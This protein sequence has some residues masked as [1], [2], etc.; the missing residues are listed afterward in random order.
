[1]ADIPARIYRRLC[2]ALVQ[3]A[4]FADEAALRAI[5]ADGRI[6][7]WRDTLRQTDS[8][9]A[10]VQATIAHLSERHN[11]HGEN[12]LVLLLR[13]LADQT[14]VDD[15]RH[16]ALAQL[17]ADL[18]HALTHLGQYELCGVLGRGQYATVYK[19]RDTQTDRWVAL[20]E[21]HRLLAVDPVFLDKFNAEARLAKRLDH[22]RLVKVYK[23]DVVDGRPFMVMEL[24]A[25]S[26]RGYLDEHGAVGEALA[27]RIVA[28]VA[29]AL[30]YLH[31]QHLVHRDVK[32]SNILLRD[33]QDAV[34][35]DFGLIKAIEASQ[36]SR[37]LATGWA[38]TSSYV[39]PEL[40]QGRAPSARSDGYALGCVLYEML[41]GHRLVSAAQQWGAAEQHRQ[42]VRLLDG[43][44][45]LTEALKLVL[46]RALARDPAH[47]YASAGA[48]A[49][50]CRAAVEA[51]RHPQRW[52]D[53]LSHEIA[54]AE[55]H[56]QPA[57]VVRLGEAYA[58]V[59]PGDPAIAAQMQK[60]RAA[61]RPPEA[62]PAQPAP[63][64]QPQRRP[65]LAG[66]ALFVVVVVALG[67]G[68]PRILGDAWPP[69]SPPPTATPTSTVTPRGSQE[70][71]VLTPSP[72]PMVTKAP[73]TT[74][75]PSV[76]S[77]P[78]PIATDTPEQTA[79]DTPSLPT[80][81]PKPPPT[82]TPRPP[83]PTPEP[84]T[85]TFTPKPRAGDTRVSPEDGAVMVYVPAGEFQM[86][87]DPEVDPDADSD[88]QPVHTVALDAFWIDQTEVTNARFATFLNAMDNR[89]EG[90]E[91]WLELTDEDCL[92][93]QVD[94]TYRAKD[95][96]AEH[97]VIEVSW[98]G[99]RAYCT[100]AG[101]RLPTEAEWEYAAR[102]PEGRIYPW[103]DAFEC[104]HG[105]FP[106]DYCDGYIRTAPVGRFPDGASWTG[107]L[108]MAGNVWEWVADWYGAYPS[109]RQ[110]NPTG[111]ETG[112][113]RVLRGGGWGLIAWY[114]RATSRY[115][116]TPTGRGHYV[117][118]RCAIAARQG[119]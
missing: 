115:R 79:T 55:R 90:G 82:D 118:F 102:G 62:S 29:E 37:S 99:A 25:R 107:A 86:G 32:P 104:A 9:A 51:A 56:G 63:A 17:A 43:A 13:V 72:S 94:D 61:L 76:T 49:Q 46:A 59:Q 31:A 93:E 89:E 5:F 96:Y 77:T 26:L 53:W 6:S 95:G 52:L 21:L 84:P 106:G 30:D 14:P 80:A 65:W 98:Y 78:E 97:P 34:L 23:Q 110:E 19:A 18:A 57:R 36:A 33:D 74:D 75:T 22:P 73:T 119:P 47:R 101:R 8:P 83:S 117:G 45:Q 91:T 112:E 109:G 116:S 39:A 2:D 113:Y 103:G 92:I 28:Q 24:A 20:K 66:V 27:V 54:W 42:S 67:W 85:P 111:P 16:R 114:G 1:M 87:S 64:P 50:A 70:V 4:C 41:T 48:F 12:A 100:W 3:C 38:G 40:W 69:W 35:G 108:D 71:A 68:V 58:R 105:N 11:A 44:D 10:R 88:E 15:A 81:T 7:A 60:A